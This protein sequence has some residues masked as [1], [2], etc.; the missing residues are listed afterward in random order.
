LTYVDLYRYT[1]DGS[2]IKVKANIRNCN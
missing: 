1:V 2:G